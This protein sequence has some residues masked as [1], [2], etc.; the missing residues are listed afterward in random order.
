MDDE[1]RRTAFGTAVDPL[2]YDGLRPGYRAE[3]VDWLLGG[4]ARPLTVLDLA[5]GTG[6][7]TRVLRPGGVLGLAWNSGDP[8]VPLGAA[9]E[10][11]VPSGYGDV[12]DDGAGGGGARS[13][14]E[15]W[16]RVPEPLGGCE[17]AVLP[18]PL[19][20][21]SPDAVADVASTY[22]GIAIRE[23]RDAVLALVRSL[24][25]AAAEP[26]GSVVLPLVCR[27]SRYRRP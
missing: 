2:R 3:A 23:D 8:A 7:L 6:T 25:A 21:P 17:R 1:R 24:A 15:W 14:E 19:R 22:A 10:R 9:F 20:L 26:D 13:D 4:P 18:A 5:A 27:C 11:L 16:P 12:A